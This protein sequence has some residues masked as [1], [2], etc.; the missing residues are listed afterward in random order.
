MVHGGSNSRFGAVYGG[1][2]GQ[3]GTSG[4]KMTGRKSDTVPSTTAGRGAC[5]SRTSH[6]PAT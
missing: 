2:N 3:N 6:V 5:Q 1:F 4:N